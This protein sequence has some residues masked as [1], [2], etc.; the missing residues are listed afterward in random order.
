MDQEA[1][2]EIKVPL[3]P[4]EMGKAALTSLYVAVPE[5]VAQD[6]NE[7]VRAWV[8]Y[9]SRGRVKETCVHCGGPQ[10]LIR[11]GCPGKDERIV[12]PTCCAERLDQIYSLAVPDY[13][14]QYAA[15]DTATATPGRGDYLEKEILE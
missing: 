5:K 8:Q 15:A 9:V 1:D 13:G 7:K 12:C 10:M 3:T 11:G 4:E 6:V 14:K 2:N